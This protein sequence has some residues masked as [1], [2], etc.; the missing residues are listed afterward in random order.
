MSK[1]HDITVTSTLMLTAPLHQP[2]K[3]KLTLKEPAWKKGV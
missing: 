1:V 2:F 3:K